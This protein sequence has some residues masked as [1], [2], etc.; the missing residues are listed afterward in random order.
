M[1]TQPTT[2]KLQE[3]KLSG[4]IKA[5]EEQNNIPDCASMSF[6]ERFALLVDQEYIERLNRRLTNRLRKA[7]FPLQAAIEDINFRHPR[8]LDRSRVLSLASCQWIRSHD[9][10]I[11]TGLSKRPV[12]L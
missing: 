7:K 6:D 11:F 8:G 2:E 4:M 10:L 1:L 12:R 5:L 3:L 9:N